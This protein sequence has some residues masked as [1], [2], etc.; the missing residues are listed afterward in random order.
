MIG[1]TAE[2][3]VPFLG[4]WPY[5]SAIRAGTGD[6][7]PRRALILFERTEKMKTTI[8][9]LGLTAAVSLGAGQI[10]VRAHQ[11]KSVDR[12]VAQIHQ[13]DLAALPQ[14]IKGLSRRDTALE[15]GY[16]W[17][18]SQLPESVNSHLP[19]ILPASLVRLNAAAAVGRL[20][21]GA[22]S[23]VPQ[24]IH[25]LQDDLADSNAALSLGRIGP[26]ARAAVP[27]LMKA[28]QEQRPGAAS[29]LGKMGLAANAARSVLRTACGSGP[30]W[31][32]YE[33]IRALGETGEEFSA[34]N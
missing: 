27:A 33:A 34:R 26:E 32:R 5:Q 12:A 21:P 11:D 7:R 31:L 17:L 28:V 25:L 15:Q 14:I 9:S 2:S 8:V 24:L 22:K 4:G 10:L 19:E 29:A 13:L 1:A 30:E 18:R 3:A 20:G 16:S 6:A 23:S